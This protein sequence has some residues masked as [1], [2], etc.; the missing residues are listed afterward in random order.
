LQIR[1]KRDKITLFEGSHFTE[2][3]CCKASQLIGQYL[4]INFLVK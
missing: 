3:N 2:I 4:F 1:I